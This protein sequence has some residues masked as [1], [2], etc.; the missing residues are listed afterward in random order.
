MNIKHRKMFF[1]TILCFYPTFAP[2][3]GSVTLLKLW[4]SITLQ[5]YRTNVYSDISSPIIRDDIVISQSRR[6]L[7]LEQPISDAAVLKDCG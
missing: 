2:S 7:G 4:C 5:F 6:N 1:R 3:G